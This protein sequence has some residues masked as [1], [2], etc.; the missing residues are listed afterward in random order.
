MIK[1]V[2][3]WLITAGQVPDKKKLPLAFKLVFEEVCELEDGCVIDNRQQVL[4]G[5]VDSFWVLLNVAYFY[6]ITP[7]EL[8]DYKKKVSVS[9]W[10]KFCKN[11]QEAIDTVDAYLS[12]RHWDKPNIN[13]DCYYEKHDAWWIVKRTDGKILKS[14]NYSSIDKL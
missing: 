6:G 5:L 11:E 7:Q 12:G 3:D 8:E 14:I 1:D 4:D 9:N 2:Y 13:V 10:S